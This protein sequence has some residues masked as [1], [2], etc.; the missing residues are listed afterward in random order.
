MNMQI[1]SI[2]DCTSF[3]GFWKTLISLK[4]FLFN[5]LSASKAALNCG[6]TISRSFAASSASSC[7]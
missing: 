6:I 3:G 4:S 5:I 2:T 1:A 7:V